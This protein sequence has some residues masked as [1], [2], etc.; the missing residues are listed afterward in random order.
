MLINKI[1]IEGLCNEDEIKNISLKDCK[2]FNYNVS[3]KISN[4]F[5]IKDIIQISLNTEISHFKSM[6]FKDNTLATLTVFT[7]FNIL[8]TEN[9]ETNA[10]SIIER[11]DYFNHSFESNKKSLEE[12][13]I[14]I[15][16]CYFKLVNNYEIVGTLTY[17]F[18]EKEEKLNLSSNDYNER[19]NYKLIDIKQEFA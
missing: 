13:N 14:S 3:F 16:D 7:T 1:N 15:I 12:I 2:V 17:L 11:E 8:T 5:G 19:T 6:E 9:R 4:D 18:K 10:L